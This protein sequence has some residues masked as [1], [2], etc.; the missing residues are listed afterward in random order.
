MARVSHWHWECHKRF[1]FGAVSKSLRLQLHS[2]ERPTLLSFGAIHTNGEWQCLHVVVA[3]SV[4]DETIEVL[5]PLGARP[6]GK[7]GNVRFQ[8]GDR[9]SRVRVVGNSYSV[10][11]AVGIGILRWDR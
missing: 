6:V 4:T 9:P 8:Q 2:N 1:N 3:I 11:P 10:N 7:K 5:D